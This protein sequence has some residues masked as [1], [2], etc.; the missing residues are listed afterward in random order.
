MNRNKET[1]EQIIQHLE[2]DPN[3]RVLC[4]IIGEDEEIATYADCM[5]GDV[6]DVFRSLIKYDFYTRRVM[7][8]LCIELLEEAKKEVEDDI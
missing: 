2:K 7:L 3:A 6:R 1:K 5:V 8:E 4:M